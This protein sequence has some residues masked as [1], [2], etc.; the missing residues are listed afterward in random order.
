MGNNANNRSFVFLKATGKHRES[1]EAPSA[2]LVHRTLTKPKWC[3]QQGLL[4]ALLSLNP[5]LCNATL[6]LDEFPVGPVVVRRYETVSTRAASESFNHEMIFVEDGGTLRNDSGSSLTNNGP[7]QLQ[8]STTG[9]GSGGIFQNF[10]QFSNFG[11]DPFS[12]LSGQLDIQGTITNAGNFTNGIA[13]VAGTVTIS[14][15]GRF[16]NTDDQRSPLTDDGIVRNLSGSTFTLADPSASFNNES[17]FINNG[18]LVVNG[19]FENAANAQLVVYSTPGLGIPATVTSTDRIINNGRVEVI[20]GSLLIL[21]S[22]ATLV[23]TGLYLQ[24]DAGT[25][26]IVNGLLEQDE[27]VIGGGELC[28]N[29]TVI[30]SLR[31][32]VHQDATVCPGSSLGML[33]VD[34]DVAFLGRYLAEMQSIGLNDFLNID[35]ALNLGNSS[36]LDLRFGAGVNVGDSFSILRA[37]GITGSFQ[38]TLFQ[39]GFAGIVSWL[40]GL[41]TVTITQTNTGPGPGPTPVPAPNTLWLFGCGLLALGVAKR[42]QLFNSL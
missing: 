16:T 15:H 30:S 25:R 23:G 19:L 14:N 40:D 32:V 21:E 1:V 38:Q 8:P 20:G 9:L 39:E 6:I 33:S 2:Q 34:A 31:L 3:L 41:L 18:T 24:R 22:S 42:K 28:G 13:G 5:L 37:S 35:G 10:G 17:I 4:C 11:F 26:T 29:G 7:I 36:V 27:V 12:L